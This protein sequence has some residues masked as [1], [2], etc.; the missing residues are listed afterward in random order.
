MTCPSCGHENREAARICPSCGEE[1]AL[2]CPRCSAQLPP[3]AR[4]CYACGQRVG[5][6]PQPARERDPRD[7]TPRHLAD[8]ILQSKSALEGERKQVSVLFADV[9]GSL[10]LAERVDPE[11][12]HRIL[13]CFF[14]ILA[15]G[16]HRFEGTVNQY[17]GDGIMALF[18]APIAHEDH[19]QRA[20][21]AALHLSDEIRRYADELRLEHGLNFS[22]RMGLNSGEVIVG[23]IGGDLRMDYTAQGH[24]VGLASRMVQLAEPGKTLLTEHTAKLA[25]GFF[26]LRDLGTSKIK[27][28]AET[29]HVFE[30]QGVGALRTRLEVSR[31]RGFSKFVGREG[32]MQALEAALA[33]SREVG[34]QVVGVVGEAGVGKSRLCYE[35]VERCRARGLSVFEGRAEA[36][37]RNVPFL[38]M[39]HIFRAYFGIGELDND[40]AVREKIAGR[41]LLT[42][43]GFREVLPLLFEFFGVPDPVQP[44]PRMDP[45]ASQRQLFGV[46]R[47]LVRESGEA[48]PSVTLIED[49][50]W[51]DGGSLAFLEQW[52]EAIGGARGLLLVDFRPEYHAEWMGK[53]YYRQLRVAPLGPEATREL[54]VDL[55]GGDASAE[56][57]AESIHLRTAGNPFF[58]EEVVQSLIE[59][60]QL[61]GTRGSYRLVSE[62]GTLQVPATVQAVVAARIDRL[63][64]REKQVLQSA[65]VIGREFT[66]PVLEAAAELRG[67]D[68]AESLRALMGTELLYEQSLYPVAEYA[69]N[70]PLTQEVAYGSQLG[71]HRARVHASVAR[72]I[73]TLDADKLDERSALLAHHWEQA[74][75]ALEAARWHARAAGWVRPSD[76]EA[77]RSHWL[78]V[79]SL[80]APLEDSQEKLGLD[81][82]ACAQ[83]MQL[84]WTLGAPVD[85]IE[86]LFAEGKALAERIPD[87]V[88]RTM[89]QFGYAQYVGLSG[90]DV[91]HYL[92]EAREA[93]RLAEAAGNPVYRLVARMVLAN[94]LSYAGNPDE[95]LALMEQCVA[96]RPEN[97]LA[98]RAIPNISPWITAVMFRNW[99]LGL[100][101]R[102]DELD[103]GLRHATELTREYGQ[104][105]F[106]GW[107]LA[108][109]AAHGE[110]SGDTATALAS[111]QQSVDVAE[112]VGVSFF[113]SIAL[114][115]LGDA[116]RLEQRYPEALE[117]YQ[118]ALD[119]MR[120]KRVALQWKP[121]VIGGQALV[122]SALGGHDEAIAQ[123]RSALE[124][125]VRGGNRFGEG[126]ARLAL[127][128]VLL[129]TADP[130][131]HDEVEETVERGQTLCE[132]T[133]MRVHLPP[134]L[135]VRASLAE[136]RG[137]PQEARRQLR[138]ARRLYTEIGATGHAERLAKQFSS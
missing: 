106:L 25:A 64:E 43:E 44:T 3:S 10:E 76:Q 107:G 117:V 46:L 20:C 71:K 11:E 127:A 85:E 102:L 135:E 54:V 41:L 42:D 56:G 73:E 51:M 65:A 98:G 113:L 59:S 122:D 1:L 37:G 129:A 84:G 90:G 29:I 110:W 72:T 86:A 9:K 74:G 39:L 61:T 13:D 118:R 105:E 125:S 17:T 68:L 26:V 96:E 112:R 108:V 94:A 4:F 132:Q 27:G 92:S 120:T 89:L 31:A 131:L 137:D 136:C 58:T 18:G 12:W 19:T 70:H 33:R 128:R 114:A 88:P 69:F 35:F 138:E 115:L 28:L 77:A 36:H 109:R 104:L 55:L 87:P 123:A 130:S 7:Y 121:V 53:S 103:Q 62:L 21:Y 79:R 24:T 93:V 100:L 47:H 101:G 119:L 95:S 91:T 60:G 99:P 45:E 116:L 5:E 38:P 40:R 80:L 16:V 82:M 49:L 83:L 81:L 133:G 134:L 30:L 111:A 75:E 8:K 97:P 52:V 22:V 78:Q 67:A 34:G 32:D 14:Q 48:E 57:L 63:P 15:N 2:P 66:E 124:E 23:K 50:H 126:V 6:S